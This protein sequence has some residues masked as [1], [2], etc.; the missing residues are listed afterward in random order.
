[1]QNITIIN[2]I[3]YKLFCLTINILMGDFMKVKPYV[4]PNYGIELLRIVSILM[5]LT[6]HIL[7]HGGVI[8]YST[9]IND[10]IAYTLEII[11]YGCVDLFALISGFV[12]VNVS[13]K[14][15]R[16]LKIWTCVSYW[17]LVLF[18][19][20]QFLP[21]LIV[22]YNNMLASI[23]P[24]NT[25]FSDYPMTGIEYLY[26]I[27]PIGSKQYWYVNAY[28]LMFIFIPILNAG[29]NKL[30]KKSLLYI[31][32]GAILLTSVYKTIVDKDLFV[33]SG[34]YSCMWLMIMYLTGGCVRK[35]YDDGFRIKKWICLLG[36]IGSCAITAIW[37]IVTSELYKKYT[38]NVFLKEKR[39]LLISYV[40]PFVVLGT[41]FLLLLFMQIDIKKEKVG[42]V[43][44]KISSCSFGI[45]IIHVH[46]GIWEYY[47]PNRF[48]T[49]ADLNPF[50]LVFDILLTAIILY[51]TC[52]ILE[53]GRKFI[54]KITKFDKLLDFL[55]DKLDKVFKKGETEQAQ[56]QTQTK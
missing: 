25:A 21:K 5:V 30:S 1:M 38:E 23:L 39:T 53:L 19:V 3:L 16:Y 6:L 54:F 11:T 24:V 9:G 36:F 31:C 15:K 37:K 46:T 20:V 12:N 13:W 28:T 22:G 40:G 42:N 8:S 44:R 56:V 47:L 33:V 17:C 51:T 29:I 14:S 2:E 52:L 50:S 35:Y 45:Y 32:L 34:G 7:G 48:K 41:I 10:H 27:F 26:S 49:Y 4:K 18:F 55:G 43:I